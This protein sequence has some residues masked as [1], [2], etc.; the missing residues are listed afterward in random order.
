LVTLL[1]DQKHLG[2]SSENRFKGTVWRMMEA[3]VRAIG[4]ELG[5]NPKQCKA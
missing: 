4:E 3:T 2:N 5:K 1:S